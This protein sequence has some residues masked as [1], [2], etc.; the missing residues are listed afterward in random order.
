MGRN[1][2]WRRPNGTSVGVTGRL[3][4]SLLNTNTN[5]FFIIGRRVTWA[6]ITIHCDWGLRNIDYGILQKVER[7]SDDVFNL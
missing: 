6:G 5:K 7:F 4:P 1:R 3:S 2:F